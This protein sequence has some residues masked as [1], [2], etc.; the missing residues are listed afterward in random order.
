MPCVIVAR[1]LEFTCQAV[2][3]FLPPSIVCQPQRPG[4]LRAG[5]ADQELFI[6]YVMEHYDHATATLRAW[7]CCLRPWRQPWRIHKQPHTADTNRPKDEIR[8]L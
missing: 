2:L 3:Q 4:L 8:R 7:C 6:V 1:R 5:L